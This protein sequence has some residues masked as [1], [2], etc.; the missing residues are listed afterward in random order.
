MLSLSKA[1]Q[2]CAEMLPE[3]DMDLQIEND[4]SVKLKKIPFVGWMPIFR[5][6][7]DLGDQLFDSIDTFPDVQ[8]WNN[9]GDK[10]E[11]LICL[12]VLLL[13]CYESLRKEISLSDDLS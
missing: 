12:N 10:I 5:H 8:P 6:M 7:L 2:L 3:V 13:V 11:R 9:L 4:N 1:L